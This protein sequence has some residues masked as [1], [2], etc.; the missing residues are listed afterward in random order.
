MMN[1]M[2]TMPKIF[3]GRGHIFMSR[4]LILV[5]VVDDGF[6]RN[7]KSSNSDFIVAKLFVLT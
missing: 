3:N 7:N 4:T 1:G 5:V 6:K 2:A